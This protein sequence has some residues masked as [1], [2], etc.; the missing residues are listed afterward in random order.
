[1][2]IQ[3]AVASPPPTDAFLRVVFDNAYGWEPG[4]VDLSVA[5]AQGTALAVEPGPVAGSQEVDL[6]S[7]TSGPVTAGTTTLQIGVAG[8]MAVG[9]EVSAQLVDGATGTVLA[10][11][12]GGPYTH[13]QVLE[14]QD[15][16]DMCSSQGSWN[17][18][19]DS[20]PMVVTSD[21]EYPLARC[22]VSYNSTLP[23]SVQ[24]ARLFYT[25]TAGALAAAGFTAAG[26]AQLVQVQSQFQ[27]AGSVPQNDTW[28]VG[29]D[30]SL[31]LS[32]PPFT[33]DGSGDGTAVTLTAAAGYTLRHTAALDGTLT[34]YGP[35]GRLLATSNAALQVVPAQPPHDFTG[36]GR[37]DLYVMGGGGDTY[38]MPGT[39]Q[40]A[41]PFGAMTAHG[42]EPTTLGDF[43]TVGPVDPADQQ[44]GT[45]IFAVDRAT[46]H[47]V[48]PEQTGVP[49]LSLNA[50]SDLGGNW[51]WAT[52]MTGTAAL[53]QP[54][55]GDLLVRDGHGNLWAYPVS[56]SGTTPLGHASRLPGN[57]N[58]A[59]QLIATGDLTG[60]GRPDLLARDSHGNLWLYP[61]TGDAANPYGPA[62]KVPGNWNWATAMAVPGDLTGDGRPDLLARDSH[63]NLWLYPGTG[64]AAD[65]FGPASKAPGNWNWVASLI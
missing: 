31:T 52:A 25:F 7:A 17:P 1:M 35:T 3:V 26:F 62:H 37:V 10:Q 16:A 56:G 53:G 20:A 41:R 49:D 30:G 13:V 39:G 47:L 61:G 21:R 57:W 45:L 63:G 40:A 14:V 58:W 29:P 27:G 9:F 8:P 54:G 22:G 43:T 18:W 48:E 11:Q 5:D 44:P 64:D 12:S 65:P 15:A 6:G 4:A 46:G 60:D 28:T 23:Q 38:L 59:T 55:P 2:D 33:I 24:G 51:R 32:L 42:T 19:S 36:D 50:Y 34:T